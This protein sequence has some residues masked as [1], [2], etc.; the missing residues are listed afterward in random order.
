MKHFIRVSILVL[1]LMQ[2]LS[3]ITGRGLKATLLFHDWLRSA[4]LFGHFSHD[5]MGRI[6]YSPSLDMG[7]FF[8]F[9]HHKNPYDLF[10]ARQ[11]LGI[12][13]LKSDHQFPYTGKGQRQ[14]NWYFSNH[15]LPLFPDVAQFLDPSVQP[16]TFEYPSTSYCIGSSLDPRPHV[17]GSKRGT[18]KPLS[19]GLVLN[20]KTGLINLSDSAPG[21]YRIVYHC[22]RTGRTDTT[23]IIL[24]PSDKIRVDFPQE[25]FCNNY[26]TVKPVIRQFSGTFSASDVDIDPQ[27]GTFVTDSLKPGYYQIQ[28]KTNGQCP[29][30]ANWVIN[31]RPVSYPELLVFPEE[32]HEGEEILFFATRGSFCEFSINDSVVQPKSLKS[33]H[34]RPSPDLL[35]NGD[36]V[37]VE[38]TNIYNCSAKD[39]TI[40]TVLQK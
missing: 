12:P 10:P 13:L 23:R 37:T 25:E 3:H 11:A 4:Q 15:I 24:Y 9:L 17:R 28:Y 30:I 26:G 14:R 2:N 32:I 6:S 38:A 33:S 7:T 16:L 29:L 22:R 35:H 27:L 19:S 40:I 8:S 18:F 21:H 39:S 36:K 1:I 20:T 5:P 31:I 34:F